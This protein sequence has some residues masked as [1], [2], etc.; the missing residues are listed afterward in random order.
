[1]GTEGAGNSKSSR[2][3]SKAIDQLILK[4]TWPAFF[5]IVIRLT[6]LYRSRRVHYNGENV[7]IF[8]VLFRSQLPAIR[9]RVVYTKE[10]R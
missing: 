3:L 5:Q 7:L 9:Y 1:M 2:T 8:F 10:V 4:H 6:T